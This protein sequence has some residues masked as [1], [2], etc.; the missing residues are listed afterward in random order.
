MSSAEGYEAAARRGADWL[1]SR[2][3]PDGGFGETD[4]ACYYKAPAALG[5]AGHPRQA[6]RL[7]E[8][9]VERFGTPE[10]DFVTAEGVKS[11]NP[12]FQEFWCYPNGWL[13]LAAHRLGW[14]GVAHQAYRHLLT[15]RTGDGGFSANDAGVPD[16][17]STAHLGLLALTLGDLDTA[18]AAGDWLT[19]L[20][21]TQPHLATGFHL[22]ADEHGPR[23]ADDSPLHVLRTGAPDQP[24]FMIGYPLAY[25]TRLHQLGGDPAHLTAAIGYADYALSCGEHLR[26]TPFSHKV[27]WGAAILARHG[28]DARHRDLA[29]GIADHL[30]SLQAEDGSW[31]PDGPAYATF[32]DTAEI[33]HWL[34]EI[35]AELP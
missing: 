21:V 3:R 24:Y 1:L 16:A 7:L 4:L 20:L 12:V 10:G 29:T 33:T 31:S 15:Y 27:G 9:A 2:L 19:K 13:A 5:L 32:D 23:T 17:I 30:V 34:L 26:S 8:V 6:R 11:A 25:L 35:A 28:H 14:F 22:R 18:R